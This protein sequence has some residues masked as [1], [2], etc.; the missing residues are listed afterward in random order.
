MVRIDEL[1]DNNERL[2]ED[3]FIV[4]RRLRV[5]F[6]EGRKRWEWE[7]ERDEGIRE[8]M[9]LRIKLFFEREEDGLR[10]GLVDFGGVF[11]GNEGMGV[12]RVLVRLLFED[13]KKKE[14]FKKEGKGRLKR[15]IKVDRMR[16]SLVEEIRINI[17]VMKDLFL[18]VFGDNKS[19]RDKGGGLFFGL[20]KRK[21]G[22]EDEGEKLILV[23]V[24]M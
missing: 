9:G 13:G 4:N 14:G 24:L 20:K 16:E 8:R 2:W 3:L 11:E 22:V 23:L 5:G 17:R 7:G 18:V 6:R 21:W 15:E 10:V 12:E 1:W 19:S